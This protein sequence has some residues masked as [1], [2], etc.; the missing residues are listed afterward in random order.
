M[1]RKAILVAAAAVIAAA[2]CV[3]ILSS[4]EPD[5]YDEDFLADRIAT[6]MFY[7]ENVLPTVSGLVATATAG[8]EGLYE[9]PLERL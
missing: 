6:A 2:V 5:G 7:A 1:G 8:S 3:F 4:T 9:I